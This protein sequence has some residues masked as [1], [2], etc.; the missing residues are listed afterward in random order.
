M[1][2]PAAGPHP[3]M[4]SPEDVQVGSAAVNSKATGDPLS[5][6]IS[7][8]FPLSLSQSSSQRNPRRRPQGGFRVGPIRVTSESV[9]SESLPSRFNPSHFRVGSIRDGSESFQ[10]RRV[11]S[12]TDPSVAH[13]LRPAAPGVRLGPTRSLPGKAR[14]RRPAA[15]P[16]EAARPCGAS[17]RLRPGAR[18]CAALGCARARAHLCA[19]VRVWVRVCARVRACVYACARAG[20]AWR[21]AGNQRPTAM[22]AARPASMNRQTRA[23]GARA[24]A[25]VHVRSCVCESRRGI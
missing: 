24:P 3:R 9:Q 1:P 7:L 20:G 15:S 2:R 8:S 12:P 6:K 11:S 22:P 10:G 18:G 5:Q 23:C 16:A 14:P 4:A 25:H 21:I 17:P 13:G 19:R